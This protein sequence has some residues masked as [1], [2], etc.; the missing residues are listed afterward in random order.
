MIKKAGLFF[1]LNLFL[2]SFSQEITDT[3]ASKEEKPI[4][5]KDTVK[6]SGN[7]E[8]DI[9]KNFRSPQ[10][11]ALYSAV[12]PGLGQIYNR[13]YIKAGLA[14]ALIGTGIGFTSFYQG[15]YQNFR[16]GY[17]NRLN[18]PSYQY[19][20]MNISAETLANNMDDRRRSRDYAVLLTALA[21]ILNIVDA[22]VDAH[23]DPV[24]KDPDLKLSPVIIQ[25]QN[26]NFE[27]QIGIGLNFKF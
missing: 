24:R 17:I 6:L 2:F 7:L 10:K 13:K 25:E 22:T 5:V 3:V 15:Q 23:L 1:F 18:D 4:I 20:G 11:A 14:L 12:F 16:E 21:Y 26:L 27:P 19:N 8:K 9:E